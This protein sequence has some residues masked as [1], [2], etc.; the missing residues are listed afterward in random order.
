MHL[1]FWI[2]WEQVS[3]SFEGIKQGSNLEIRI[4]KHVHQYSPTDSTSLAEASPINVATSPATYNEAALERPEMTDL[5]V[6][7][8]SKNFTE[9]QNRTLL[10]Y[11]EYH[12]AELTIVQQ[13][14]ANL[15]AGI[16]PALPEQ[17][18]DHLSG[19][20]AQ[21]RRRLSKLRDRAAITSEYTKL[22]ALTKS[23][24]L[25]KRPWAGW[26]TSLRNTSL[27]WH[28]SGRSDSDQAIDL[29][30]S[31]LST[32]PNSM[33]SVPKNSSA[34]PEASTSRVDLVE[35][36]RRLPSSTE[37]ERLPKI[38]STGDNSITVVAKSETEKALI[39]FNSIPIDTWTTEPDISFIEQYSTAIPS[40]VPHPVPVDLELSYSFRSFENNEPWR[41]PRRPTLLPS[42]MATVTD[43]EVSTPVALTVSSEDGRGVRRFGFGSQIASFLQP[44]DGL[45]NLK[46]Q[47]LTSI[48]AADCREQ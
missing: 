19:R 30:P 37:R 46:S 22:Q 8:N 5:R 23:T 40:H 6:P 29:Y 1:H 26:I 4:L 31:M 25:A 41:Q 27:H 24:S 14:L 48:P 2:F 38:A 12:D 15:Q 16:T 7:K 33:A 39:I 17:G 9:D 11:L 45:G 21:I 10:S 44:G 18:S 42:V 32:T 36:F 13:M 20:V 3:R 43:P 28:Q 35:A 34:G 47:T